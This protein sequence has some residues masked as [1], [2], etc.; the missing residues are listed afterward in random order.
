MDMRYCCWWKFGTSNKLIV[1]LWNMF[2]LQMLIKINRH[3]TNLKNKYIEI[4][5][6][7][8]KLDKLFNSKRRIPCVQKK[9]FDIQRSHQIQI[10]DNL[11]HK[12]ARFSIRWII[13]S[14]EWRNN[15]IR[16]P[17]Q[18]NNHF[19]YS[20]ILY[21]DLCWCDFSISI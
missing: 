16:N 4:F 5:R 13:H 3:P 19:L 17:K 10:T 15:K 20:M 7:N 11:I 21:I 14:W 2:I 18:I 1:I 9:Y 8:E 12:S 6:I